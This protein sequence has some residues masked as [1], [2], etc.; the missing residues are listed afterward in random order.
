MK[1]QLHGVMMTCG[2]PVL[3]FFQLAAAPTVCVDV[4]VT[5][6]Y[7]TFDGVSDK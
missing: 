5:V 2:L 4:F 3:C 6:H 1:L 7:A